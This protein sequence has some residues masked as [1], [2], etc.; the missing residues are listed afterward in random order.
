MTD[1]QKFINVLIAEDNEVSRELM[2]SILK[3][4]GYNILFAEDGDSAIAVM[5]E[6]IIDLAYV[7]INMSPKGGFELIKHMVARNI[8]TPVVIVTADTSGDILLQANALGV[9]N[10]FHKPVEPDRFLET[11]RRVL[12]Q[13]GH[14]VDALFKGTYETKF[15]PEDLMNRAIG[16]ARKNIESKKGG[17]FGAV[18]ADQE[19]TIL[20]E[21]T[22]GI[23]SRLDPTAHAEVMAIR[24]AAEKLGRANLSDCVLYCSSEPT[25]M[26]KALIASV[27]IAQVYYGLSHPD[28]GVSRENET[29]ESTYEQLGQDAA[30][31]LF[32]QWRAMPDEDKARLKD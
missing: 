1:H 8:K 17:P 23:S 20:G 15:S 6:H 12:R 32:E 24:Q 22:N 5:N 19:G 26:G 30:L 21:G 29:T 2:A 11:T 13:H 14:N 16:L 28:T 18:V 10:V 9:D 31:H 25:M 27:G 4:H 3:P 7:D